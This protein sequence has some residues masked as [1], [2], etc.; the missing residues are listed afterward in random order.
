MQAPRRPKMAAQGRGRPGRGWQGLGMRHVS[1]KGGTPKWWFS[2]KGKPLS[3]QKGTLTMRT[4]AVCMDCNI[5]IYIPM[6]IHLYIWMLL[7]PGMYTRKPPRLH[8]FL[9]ILSAPQ[10][11]QAPFTHNWAFRSSEHPIV[12]GP[13][14][15]GH[16]KPDLLKLC[17]V[18]LAGLNS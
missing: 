7:V 9:R 5:Y 18:R 8:F 17:A 4:Q 12:D 11:K 14:C 2:C 10:E 15:A 1:N 6:Y 3:P 16:S 13:L